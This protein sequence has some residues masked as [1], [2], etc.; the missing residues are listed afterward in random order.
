[1][2]DQRTEMELPRNNTKFS[3]YYANR[4]EKTLNTGH[5]YY[6]DRY[7]IQVFSIFIIKQ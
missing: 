1:M 2:I 4:S 3:Q 6:A 5:T 7:S